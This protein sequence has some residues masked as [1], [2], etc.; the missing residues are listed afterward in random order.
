MFE[1]PLDRRN[2]RRLKLPYLI[3]L[4]RLGEATKVHTTTENISSEGFYCVSEQPFSPNEEVDC[5]VVIPDQGSAR[6]E[7]EHSIILHC[8]AEV[9]RVI[10]DGLKPGYGLACRLR[11]YSVFRQAFEVKSTAA[12]SKAR[13][14]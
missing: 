10:A 8:K 3:V 5:E 12:C 4:Q 6:V 14:A 9:V 7:L 13:G 11:D 1:V 2:R